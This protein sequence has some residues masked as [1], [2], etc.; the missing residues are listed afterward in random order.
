MIK[1]EEKKI[2]KVYSQAIMLKVMWD[3]TG[4]KK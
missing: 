1:K 2:K 3:C 4:N